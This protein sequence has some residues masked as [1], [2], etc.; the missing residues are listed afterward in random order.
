ML[1]ITASDQNLLTKKKKAKTI[2]GLPNG[3]IARLKFITT[4]EEDPVELTIE[5]AI[6]ESYVPRVL[7]SCSTPVKLPANP[8]DVE[9]FKRSVKM[10]GQA[11]LFRQPKLPQ[12]IPA[13][14]K[15]KM[16][17]EPKYPSL[18][19]LLMTAHFSGI[20]L[21]LYHV[22]SQRNS[23]RKL[24][25]NDEDFVVNVVRFESTL[26]LRRFSQYRTSDKNN[27]GFR[28]EEMCVSGRKDN[29]DFNQLI[30]GK[31]GEFKVLMMGEVDTIRKV[32][33]CFFF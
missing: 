2:N 29:F 9:A 26:Y 11:P 3:L 20:N 4:F 8:L 33:T 32:C 17:V 6:F 28:F 7:S 27:I 1:Q 16:V 21:R 24:A 13:L 12:R 30:D 31:I 23:L 18:I 19:P 25:M 10:P 15:R 22:V 14:S 5:S